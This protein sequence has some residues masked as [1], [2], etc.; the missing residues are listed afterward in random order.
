[1][2]TANKAVTYRNVSS[3]KET[4]KNAPQA[5]SYISSTTHGAIKNVTTKPVNMITET[6]LSVPQDAIS[7]I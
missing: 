7:I 1:M 5:V 6:V 3:I 2:D 4:V